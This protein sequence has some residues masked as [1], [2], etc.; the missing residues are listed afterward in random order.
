MGFFTDKRR[1]L[2]SLRTLH[3]QTHPQRD[4]TIE[5]PD[6]MFVSC[7]KC[8]GVMSRRRLETSLMVCPLC[9]YHRPIPAPDRL[10]SIVDDGYTQLDEDLMGTDP[11]SFP[12]YAEKVGRLQET[13]GL[14]EAV[15]C[16]TGLVGGHE[17]VVVALDTRFIMGSM[18]EA[19]GERITRAIETSTDR[20]LPLI[21]FSASGGARMQEGIFSLMQMAKT[22][23]AVARHDEAGLL[24]V[25]VLTHPTTGG[26]TASFASLGDV[27]LAEP[28]A[29]IG[30]AGP[31]V[32]EQTIR[33][34]LPEGF[35]RAE[36]VLDC[37]F[38]DAI[39]GRPQ[40]RETLIGLLE[41]H[42]SPHEPAETR[43]RGVAAD[44]FKPLPFARHAERPTEAGEV[45]AAM[46]VRMARDPRRPDARAYIGALF[47][48]FIELHGDRLAGDD[49][50]VV[51]GVAR[52]GGRPV[53]VI[54]TCKGHDLES[55]LECNFGMPEPEGYRKAR[56]LAEQAAKFG[57]P[58][59]TF[60]DTPGAYP[61]IEAE[62]HGQGEA[63]ARSIACFARLKVPVIAV[64]T[65]EGGS[66]GALALAVGDELIMLENSIFSIVSPEGFSAILWK[67]RSRSD[68][69]CELMRLTAADLLEAGVVDKVIPEGADGVWD[70][71]DKVF[72]RLSE[73][74]G[75]ALARL[76]GFDAEELVA[77]RYE[78][79]RALGTCMTRERDG[80]VA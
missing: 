47:E 3:A 72:R 57:R 28:G 19:V 51:G 70:E 78:R 43:K 60:I 61:G 30:F 65:G 7:P 13:T 39:V 63:I 18:G 10:A 41:M 71:R 53:T 69:A 68:E 21:I 64:I 74:I 24:Y 66:G 36:S 1:Q 35:Q 27:I 33:Q 46:R 11:L 37:G 40:M 6:G 44:L 80:G 14:T 20:G 38:I 15:V 58:V 52:I 77:R 12:G 22:A 56:R 48:D 34:K 29:L 55:N 42:E 54:G 23:A 17:A 9:G 75:S 16:A 4:E 50:G 25:S 31:R 59:I 76:D 62:E 5:I 79:F 45:T 2:A 32:I 67:D 8:A 49:N 73:A 26:V